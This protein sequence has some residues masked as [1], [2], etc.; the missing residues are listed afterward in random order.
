MWSLPH[1]KPDTLG[2]AADIRKGHAH[3]P[4]EEPG[5][6]IIAEGVADF[7]D[8]HRPAPLSIA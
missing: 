5:W 6:E 7:I 1:S 3:W 8:Q 2:V 4:Q